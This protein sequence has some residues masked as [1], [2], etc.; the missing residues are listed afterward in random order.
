MD[1]ELLDQERLDEILEHFFIKTSR[2]YNSWLHY[3]LGKRKEVSEDMHI[4]EMEGFLRPLFNVALKV[5][6]DGKRVSKSDLDTALQRKLHGHSLHLFR[7]WQPTDLQVGKA[8][9]YL[10]L[11]QGRMM[12][13]MVDL[14]EEDT[15]LNTLIY[16]PQSELRSFSSI[17]DLADFWFNERIRFLQSTE[18]EIG[19]DGQT[20]GYLAI[21]EALSR[22]VEYYETRSNNEVSYDE[23]VEKII[24]FS[25][26]DRKIIE[27]AASGYKPRLRAHNLSI[28]LIPTREEMPDAYNVIGTKINSNLG[29]DSYITRKLVHAMY[30]TRQGDQRA[31]N[32]LKDAVKE[33]YDN[34]ADSNPD[35]DEVVKKCTALSKFFIKVPNMNLLSRDYL[36]TV[37][38]NLARESEAELRTLE[39]D[40]SQMGPNVNLAE[41]YDKPELRRAQVKFQSYQTVL[42]NFAEKGAVSYRRKG[43]TTQLIMIAS[44]DDPA[45]KKSQ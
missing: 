29:V 10:N 45:V 26:G 22:T 3:A 32:L 7:N 23:L 16:R 8:N 27:V 37:F 35:L 18:A 19:L 42:A 4:Q 13:S 41:I 21:K 6:M 31:G 43:A 11:Y 38:Y 40:V 28:K 20:I 2:A 14:I 12:R 34:I 1:K 9:K 33:S 17:K 25:P 30:Y 24:Q 15:S 5:A 44:L 36:E 39:P